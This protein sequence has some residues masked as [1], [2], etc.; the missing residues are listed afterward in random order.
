[1]ATCAGE[2]LDQAIA[3]T[4]E[5][6]FGR[7]GIAF[8]T[9]LGAIG[10]QPDSADRLSILERIADHCIFAGHPDIALLALVILIDEPRRLAD[11][12]KQCRDLLALANCWT[13]LGRYRSAHKVNTLALAHAL[14]HK[15]H[16]DAASAST[17]L[18]ANEAAQGKLSE[19]LERLEASLAL[20]EKED[21]PDT[22]TVTRLSYL[23]VVDALETDPE[24]ALELATDLFQR[25]EPY[26]GPVRWKPV[27]PSFHRLIDRHLAK[28]PE[29][30]PDPWKRRTFP[31]VFGGNPHG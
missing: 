21:H 18:A 24:R 26:V 11:P 17:N 29:V 20:L 7:A 27:E 28:H 5:G 4:H 15:R 1:M 9:A 23:Q 6:Q 8:Q 31:L 19:A 14:R 2:S 16:A 12:A 25:L 10:D 13:S 3:L 22:E 30:D